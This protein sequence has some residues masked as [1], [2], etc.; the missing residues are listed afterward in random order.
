MHGEQLNCGA[1]GPITF[2]PKSTSPK[3]TA[4]M[5]FSSPCSG[6]A[7]SSVRHTVTRA[8][9]VFYLCSCMTSM[10]SRGVTAPLGTRTAASSGLGSWR[11]SVTVQAAASSAVDG[12]NRGIGQC[13]TIY[14]VPGPLNGRNA[15]EV[16]LNTEGTNHEHCR[17]VPGRP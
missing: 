9:S 5:W 12:L 3:L 6:P 2:N 16:K 11:R 13:F 7:A 15:V 1:I 10:R 8:Q 4:T 14:G 17:R